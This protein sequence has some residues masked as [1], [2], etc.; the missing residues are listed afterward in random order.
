MQQRE[1]G[2]LGVRTGA[3]DAGAAGGKSDVFDVGHPHAGGHVRRR[4]AIDHHLRAAVIDVVVRG[5]HGNP[6]RLE[7]HPD[8]FRFRARQLPQ[9]QKRRTRRG[10]D[11]ARV[12]GLE[13]G[14]ALLA[15]RTRDF[16]LVGPGLRNRRRGLVERIQRNRAAVLLEHDVQRG[17]TGVRCLSRDF[18]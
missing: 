6:R 11:D 7:P 1:E 12:A 14:D 4:G 10:D 9:L 16:Q 2:D 5:Q 8:R 3:G 13:L 17:E 18:E 15:E